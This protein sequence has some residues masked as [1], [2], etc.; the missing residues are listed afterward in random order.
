VP[1]SGSG[2]LAALRAL[3]QPANVT[4]TATSNGITL[5]TTASA[6]MR[7][8]QAFYGAAPPADAGQQ[9]EIERLPAGATGPWIATAQAT[10]TAAGGFSVSWWPP[11]SGRF[12]LRA[13]LASSSAPAGISPLPVTQTGTQGTQ[14]GQ[15]S[16]PASTLTVTVYRPQPATWYGPGMF[17]DRTA[18]G[19]KLH[20][21]TLG[22]A[23]LR[24]RC[25]AP[26]QLDYHGRTIV[27]PVI[28]R[29]PY[30]SNARWDLT[31]ATAI[32]LGMR[33]SGTIGVASLPPR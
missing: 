15:P 13:V 2:S 32:V 3:A 31:E 24:L 4:V 7:R 14:P 20:L 8:P 28:D 18:C 16:T 23:N 26:V 25:G 29:G 11:A 5:T 6:T 27:V 10:I 1:L 21:L 12:S 17:G 9:V 22:V 30:G 19:E 33:Q